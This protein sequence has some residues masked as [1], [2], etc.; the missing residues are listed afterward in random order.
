M[1]AV[2]MGF[3][4]SNDRTRWYRLVNIPGGLISMLPN[5]F[6]VFL[7]FGTMGHLGVLVDIGSMMTAS[8]ALGIAVDNTIHFL[9]WFRDGIRMGLSR[10]EA[11]EMA[12][13]RC[14]SA[15]TTT[16]IIGGLGLSVFILSTFTPTQRFGILMLTILIAALV[17][18]LVMNPALLAGPLGRYFEPRQRR[19]H[20][21]EESKEG[22]E[23]NA[24]STA[25]HNG[26]AVPPPHELTRLLAST[27]SPSGPRGSTAP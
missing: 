20:P 2:V 16:T 25:D 14:A 24:G 27:V 5:V 18:D 10:H 1:I 15:M 17:G 19:S 4:V 7:V 3:L 26:H 12:Y 11:I 22:T 8:V 21:R 9:T 23:N 13:Q 6:P